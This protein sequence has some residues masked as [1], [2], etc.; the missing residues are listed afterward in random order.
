M[1][2][3]VKLTIPT[4]A[5][6]AI[7]CQGQPCK[8][9]RWLPQQREAYVAALQS[10]PHLE[11]AICC[12]QQGDVQASSVELMHAISQAADASQMRQHVP[13]HSQAPQALCA[14]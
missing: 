12:A 3:E 9:R 4:A 11:R 14:P 6:P 2:L 7:I 10:N 13:V 1:P 5:L 8:A